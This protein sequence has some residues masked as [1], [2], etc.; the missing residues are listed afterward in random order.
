VASQKIQ[1]I[2]LDDKFEPTLAAQNAQQLIDKGVVALFLSRGTPHNQ[3]I[4]PLLEKNK[5]ALIAPSTGAMV[6]HK[7]VNPYV[8][9]VRAPYQR[10]SERLISDLLKKGVDKIAI[11]QV[12]DSFGDDAVSGALRA[13]AADKKKPALHL[14]FPRDKPEI[15]KLM[16]EVAK[17]PVQAVFIIGTSQTVAEGVIALRA[18]GSRAQVLTLSNNASSGFV[19]QLGDHARGVI[20]SQVFPNER[21]QT[22][23]ITREARE[24]LKARGSN[25]DDLSPAMMEGFAAAKVLVEGLKRSSKDLS[26][27]GLLRTLD[28]MQKVDLGGMEV[29]YSSQDHSGTNFADISIIGPNGKFWR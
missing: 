10:E 20:V 28:G 17:Q 19:K 25:P 5:I 2:S 4:L 8:F 22:T 13:I 1:L 16:G 18:T 24:L 27:A 11:V 23:P 15:T 14:K 21:S 9:N 3:A 6:M 7:P 26:R 29:N 12:G